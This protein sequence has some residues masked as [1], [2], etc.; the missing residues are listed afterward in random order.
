MEQIEYKLEWIAFYEEFATRLLEYK[1]NR[2]A[3]IQKLQNVFNKINMPFPKLEEDGIVEDIDPFTVF[4]MFNKGI[5]NKK[6]TQILEEIARE[7]RIDK[8]APTYFDGIPV[9]LPMKSAFVHFKD[10]RKIDDIDNLWAVFEAAINYAEQQNDETISAFVDA[11]DKAITI[12]GVNW[13]LT[14]GLYWIRPYT[15]LNLDEKNREFMLKEKITNKIKILPKGKEYLTLCNEVKNKI[16]DMHLYE[17]L[18]Q[19]SHAAWIYAQKEY[20]PSLKEYNPNITKEQWLDLLNNPKVTYPENLEMFKMM[21]E[22]GGESTCANLAEIYG[23]S[24][25]TYNTLGRRFGQRTHDETGC[26]L[27]QDEERTR[28][29]TVPFVGRRVIEHGKPRYS[30]RLREELREALEDMDLPKIEIKPPYKHIIKFDKNQILYGPPGTGKTYN[31]AIY[32]VA[33]CNGEDVETVKEWDYE[34]VMTRYNELVSLGQITFTTFHQSYGY[35]EFI[36]GIKPIMDENNNIS[37]EVKSG[38]F[39]EFCKQAQI[40]ENMLIDHNTKLWKVILKSGDTSATNSVKSECFYSDQKIMFDWGKK[41]ECYI[42]S[43]ALRQLILFHDKMNIGDIVVVY[44][45]NSENIDAIGII[46][47]EAFYDESRPSYR[48]SRSVKWI[49]VNKLRSMKLW[50]E[51]KYFSNDTVQ[52]LK[53]VNL[54]EFMK[55]VQP[56]KFT[57]NKKNYVFIIDEIN[58]GNISKIF[59]ELITLIEDC[60]RAGQKEEASAILPYSGDSFSI[61]S[62]VYIIGTMNTADRSI[63][64]MDTALRRRFSFVEMMPDSQLLQDIKVIADGKEIDIAKMLDKMNQRIAYLYDRE[65]TIGHAF[66]MKLKDSPTIETLQ[67]IFEKSIVPLLQEYF[68]EDYEKIQLVLGD[69]GKENPD[70]KFISDENTKGKNIFKGK[71]EDLFDLPE[72]TYQINKNA[73]SE[74]ESYIQIYQ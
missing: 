18:P 45:G 7:F 14:M 4:G 46:T 9:L 52:E 25:G 56:Q 73:F 32:A 6:R 60:K 39:K 54:L 35:E 69:N 71:V 50:N 19:L 28:M 21:L 42:G 8:T 47:G 34:E 64:L 11:Y 12:N 61:P 74:A 48:W 66:F 67:N 16:V 57:A 62:N 49:E 58:R 15:F 10:S 70:Y 51:N 55:T 36:E 33:I 5:T 40:P 29:Y 26:P 37:Y 22:L 59:G 27:C 3:L 2:I 43:E 24:F 1:D 17:N 65:H 30:W 53:R 72:K 13:N 20:W 38:V 44:A 31:T 63:A 68:Y 23:K 41:D